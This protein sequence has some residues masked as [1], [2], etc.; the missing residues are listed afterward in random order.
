MNTLDDADFIMNDDS[1]LCGLSDSSGDEY[2]DQLDLMDSGSDN[3]AVQVSVTPLAAKPRLSAS[4]LSDSSDDDN[5]S[6]ADAVPASITSFAVRSGPS[7]L[8]ARRQSYVWQTANRQ[9][10]ATV[11]AGKQG[12]TSEV[13]VN[14]VDCPYEYF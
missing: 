3:D 14:D 5:D 11:F 2:D 9:R 10:Q 12:P 7:Q 1:E 13:N 6:G 8:R 4:G